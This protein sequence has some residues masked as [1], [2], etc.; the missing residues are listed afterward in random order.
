MKFYIASKL[1]NY[2]QVQYLSDKL[3][4]AGWEHTYNWAVHLSAKE[5]NI[6]LLR[7]IG[8]KEF[9]AVKDADVIIVLTPQGRG[10]HIEL[11]MAIAFNKQIY[12]C[13]TDDKYFQCDDNTSIFYWLPQVKQ[14]IGSIDDIVC[15]LLNT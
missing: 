13:H 8:Q 1:E 7:E 4:S 10:T 6:E 2:A 9:N 15:E 5:S 11:G 14:F 3:K 12:L